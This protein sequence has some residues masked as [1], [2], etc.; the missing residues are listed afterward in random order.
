[1][2][3][4]LSLDFSVRAFDHRVAV[5]EGPADDES[6]RRRSSIAGVRDERRELLARQRLTTLV[7]QHHEIVRV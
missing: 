1:M 6:A 2:T 3:I 5:S 4:E 7:H